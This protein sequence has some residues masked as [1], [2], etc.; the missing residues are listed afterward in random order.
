[1]QYEQIAVEAKDGILTVRLDRPER[2]NAYTFRM[3]EEI[4]DALDRADADD[5]VRVVVFT[6]SGRAYCAGADLEH[7]AATFDPRAHAEALGEPEHAPADFRD[8]GGKLVMRLFRSTKPL[9]AAVNGPA[10]GVGATMTLPMD[11]RLCAEEAR[12][13]FVFARRGITPDGCSTWFLPKIVGIDR[14]LEWCFTGRVFDAAE[15]LESRL[16]REVVPADALLDR[17][18]ELAHAIAERTPAVAVAVT[19]AL[20]WG[21]QSEPDPWTA[22]RLESRALHWAGQSDDAR[23]GVLAFLEKRPPRFGLRVSADLPPH[24]G[25][26]PTE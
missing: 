13:G 8:D 21:M 16:V 2:M 9:I 14:A 23:E 18:Y 3:R 7:G 24:L 25:S 20:L 10:V 26:W 5:D 17:A 15:A 6:G 19:R 22:H 4:S 11:I 12:F 1:M